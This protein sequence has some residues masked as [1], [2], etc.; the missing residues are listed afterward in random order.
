MT[1]TMTPERWQRINDLFHAS[2]GRRLEERAAFLDQACTDDADAR[3][4]VERLLDAH[5]RAGTFL[6]TPAAPEP[7]VRPLLTG[8]R[9]AHYELGQRVGVG[10]MGEVYRAI[11]GML[12]REVAIKVVAGGEPVAQAR[13]WRE[14]EHASGLNHPNICTIHQVGEAEGLAYIV[15][16]YVE[17]RPLAD[18]IADGGL[19]SEAVLRYTGQVAAAL[20][21]AHD[22]GIAHRDLKSS[23]VMITADDR[24]K[25]LDFGLARRLGPGGLDSVDTTST[26]TGAIAGTLAYMA[27]EVL[28][29]ER[30]NA[31]SDVWAFGVLLHEML[32]GERPFEGQTPFELS[33]A[34]LSQPPRRMPRNVSG[35]LAVV[36]RRCLE[37]EPANRYASGREVEA[38][39]E[40]VRAGRAGARQAL[41]LPGRRGFVL[42][43]AAVLAAA[44]A[45]VVV[46]NRASWWP[47]LG[48]GR[49]FRSLVVLP[50]TNVSGDPAHEY[51]S[52]GLTEGLIA[53]LGKVRRLRVISRTT[54]MSYRGSGKTAPRIAE[55]LGV[56]AVVEGSVVRTGDRVRVT[57][58]LIDAAADAHVWA[59]AYEA[60]VR[61]ILVLQR[62]VVRAV[63][64]G[65]RAALTPQDQARLSLVR[66]VDPAVYESYLKGRYY[67]NQRTEESLRQAIEY[68]E[69]ATSADPTF[70]PAWAALAD[71]YNQLGT[72]LV[73]VAPPSVMRPRAAAAAIHAL[74]IDPGLAEAHAT[75]G[76][77][78]HYDWQWEEAERELRLAIE[79]NPSYALARIWYANN[80]ASRRRLKEAV[81]EARRAKELD[82]L[83][84]VV[85]TNVGWTLSMAGAK[86]DAI[87]QYRRA[88]ELDP[89][90]VQAHL[91][92]GAAYSSLGRSG[93][94]IAELETAARL[95]HRNPS[96]LAAL[97]EAYARAGERR[98]A[99]ELLREILSRAADG[100]VSP[101]RVAFVYSALGDRDSTFEWLEKAYAERSNGMAY[102]GVRDIDDPIRADPRYARLLRRVGLPE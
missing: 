43:G 90:Y 48:G 24:V 8:R 67:W 64:G 3:R 23:N 76:Y 14:A 95:T 55:E 39:L 81:T 50:L 54:A 28:R 97:A 7:D 102:L 59:E 34:I 31:R 84:L 21:H 73:G 30:G 45:G 12:G 11:D 70:A 18:V 19:P 56:D 99:Q 89:S 61:D 98:K 2:L 4:A 17:G 27:P 71:C 37:K 46:R 22:R 29:G 25:V 96:S 10:G 82:P 58:Q 51:L 75:L 49:A 26:V 93:E 85:T 20:A 6:E 57:V 63:A 15:M 44:F 47:R 101:F 5:A 9:F 80:L 77:V 1:A 35:A 88:L 78:K 33:S 87:V 52:E 53:E 65:V 41:H 32:A 60:G 74:Q 68:F 91:R 38:A 42:G 100:Y 92:L 16:E 36:A 94:A 66:T 13:L 86:E 40:D 62:D 83:S 72:V 79:I 69:A